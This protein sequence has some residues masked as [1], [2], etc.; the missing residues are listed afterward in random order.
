MAQSGGNL[1][2]DGAVARLLPRRRAAIGAG[3][4]D[5]HCGVS[6]DLANSD[7]GGILASDAALSEWAEMVTVRLL[8]ELDRADVPAVA[9]SLV[10]LEQLLGV[11]LFEC[12]DLVA[13]ALARA[14]VLTEPLGAFRPDLKLRVDY[15][16]TSLMPETDRDWTAL[17]RS[18]QRLRESTD[19]RW[20][21]RSRDFV[22]LLA[23]LCFGR[24]HQLEDAL[25]LLD[26]LADGLSSVSRGNDAEARWLNVQVRYGACVRSFQ[27]ERW[28]RVVVVSQRFW[29]LYHA[30]ASLTEAEKARLA[31][32]M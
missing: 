3:L 17:L 24:L 7:W 27:L 9:L 29:E 32:A 10:E 26:P 15:L 22:E 4:A 6:Y 11:Y 8:D 30:D 5:C 16:R 25:S 28:E 20:P 1:G 14:S 13:T 19:L 2:G 31:Y 18:A 23:G 12:N 21:D